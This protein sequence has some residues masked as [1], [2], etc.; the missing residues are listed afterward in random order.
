MSISEKFSKIKTVV[1][2]QFQ[3]GLVPAFFD[4]FQGR[5][6]TF[7]LA[8]TAVGIWG[9]IRGKDLTSFALFVTAIQGLVF[10]HSVKED[11]FQI[12]HRKL[13]MQ[14]PDSGDERK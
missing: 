1:S 14:Q 9:F 8:F 13:D 6:T 11:W 10:C 2:N 7:A 3:W 5:A 4:F 12:Q